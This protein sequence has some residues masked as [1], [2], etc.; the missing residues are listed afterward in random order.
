[1]TCGRCAREIEIDSVYCRH[2]GAR[3]AATAGPAR[4]LFR[5]TTDRKI[6]G[7]CGG[8][9]EYFAVDATLV[10]LLAIVLAIYPGA[11]VLGVLVYLIAWAVIPPAPAA[12]LQPA[13]SHA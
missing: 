7:V 5:S 9:A 10:R 1:M 13:P 12:P 3:V 11:V 8:L 2:C 4:R 6:G